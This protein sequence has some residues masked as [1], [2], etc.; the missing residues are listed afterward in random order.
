MLINEKHVRLSDKVLEA[1]EMAIQQHDLDIAILLDHA[2]E[3]AMTR[4]TGGGDFVERR[5]YTERMEAAQAQLAMLKHG[6]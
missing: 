6:H 3:K 1:L 5:T 2:L 4:N